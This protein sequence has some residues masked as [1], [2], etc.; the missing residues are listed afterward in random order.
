MGE[1]KN[2]GIYPLLVRNLVAIF[3]CCVD[4]SSPHNSVAPWSPHHFSECLLPQPISR[5]FLSLS[6]GKRCNSSSVGHRHPYVGNAVTPK[7]ESAIASQLNLFCSTISLIAL[8]QSLSFQLFLPLF[9]IYRNHRYVDR[10][11]DRQ[12]RFLCCEED[13]L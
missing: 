3:I 10:H 2:F 1:L 9:C 5:T 11:N 7:K 12:Y 8:L 6:S 4:K 13:I